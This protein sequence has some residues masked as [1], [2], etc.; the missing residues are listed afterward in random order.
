MS[1]QCVTLKS[2][3]SRASRL[4]ALRAAPFAVRT[5]WLFTVNK[6]KPIEGLI[7]LP[8]VDAIFSATRPL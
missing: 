7:G 1:A 3:P 8:Q 6:D 4:C 2:R 5:C